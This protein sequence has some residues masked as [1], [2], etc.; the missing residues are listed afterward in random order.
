[1]ASGGGS[2]GSSL[3]KMSKLVAPVISERQN[4]IIKNE[5]TI[6]QNTDNSIDI[7][8]SLTITNLSN[9]FSGTKAEA[10]IVFSYIWD[11]KL[12]NEVITFNSVTEVLEKYRTYTPSGDKFYTIDE[13]NATK[14]EDIYYQGIRNEEIFDIKTFLN[15]KLK[16]YFNENFD[17]VGTFKNKSDENPT[18]EI[19]I[20]RNGS[21]DQEYSQLFPNYAIPILSEVLKEIHNY[22]LTVNDP[23]SFDSENKK[24]NIIG[25]FMLKIGLVIMT[26]IEENKSE[27]KIGSYPPFYLTDPLTYSYLK[28]IG[29]ALV[30][31]SMI[32]LDQLRYGVDSFTWGITQEDINSFIENPQGPQQY[33][34]FVLLFKADKLVTY[35][36]KFVANQLNSV[37]DEY[38]LSFMSGKTNLRE[39]ELTVELKY[40]DSDK[41]EIEPDLNNPAI[42]ETEVYYINVTIKNKQGDIVFSAELSENY[43]NTKNSLTS[44]FNFLKPYIET[45][46]VTMGDLNEI[47]TVMPSYSVRYESFIDDIQKENNPSFANLI[48]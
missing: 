18:L 34:P 39:S 20:T 9:F 47:R 44:D 33:L 38:N 8:Q 35:K 24:N 25:Q 7:I 32:H 19:D 23:L 27:L 1:M 12:L 5:D 26:A 14:L 10:S 43:K 6:K 42:Q 46:Q 31:R 4:Q 16:Q 45:N 29:N 48:L 2:S 30:G 3:T 21:S 17:P 37:T 28:T 11:D 40:L 15:S 41:N 36:E 22:F 13:N